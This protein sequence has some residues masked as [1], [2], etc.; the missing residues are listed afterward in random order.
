[1]RAVARTVREHLDGVLNAIMTQAT[2]TGAE[3]ANAKI[4]RVKRMAC[5]DRNRAR[6]HSA[7]AFH[8]SGLRLDP[9][10][11]THTDS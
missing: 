5:G 1:M 2:N 8:L 7:I 9:R 11:S 10:S 6:F 4:Q 3:S